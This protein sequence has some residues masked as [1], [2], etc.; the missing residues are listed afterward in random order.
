MDR[1]GDYDDSNAS[2][3]SDSLETEITPLDLPAISSTPSVYAGCCLGISQ[4]LISYLCS[5]LPDPPTTV[6]SIGSGY[7]LLEALMLAEHPETIIIGVEVQPSSN[8]YLPPANH[9]SVVGTRFLDPLA[10]DAEAW[11][12]VYSK[13][14]GLVDEYVNEYSRG[15]LKTIVWAGPKADWED[16]ATCFEDSPGKGIAW[17]VE[18]TSADEVGGRAWELIAVARRR[19]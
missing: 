1:D 7:G 13:R 15:R 16:Y 8:Q 11:L 18:C 6:L 3:G 14:V 12:F 5:L 19:P 17:E 2:C 4:A 10:A 9:R